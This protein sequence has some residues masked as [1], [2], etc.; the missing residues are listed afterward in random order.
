MSGIPLDVQKQQSGI[1][2]LLFQYR[3]RF[4]SN[5]EFPI[6]LFLNA[7]QLAGFLQLRKE[8]PESLSMGSHTKALLR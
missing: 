7:K 6:H 1:P 2:T 4:L 5:P 3:S 8:I